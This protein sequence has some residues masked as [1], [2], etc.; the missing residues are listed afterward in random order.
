MELILEAAP[1][2]IVMANAGGT[3]LLVNAQTEK[4]FG[5]SR[6]ELIGKNVEMLIPES[7]RMHHAAAR[8]DYFRNP[9]ARAMGVGRDLYGLC[10]DGRE[11]PLEIG[12]NPVNTAKGVFVL[13]S[14]IDITERK[15]DEEALRHE[16][17]LLRTL[18][19]NLPDYIYVK[20]L[21]RR[22]VVANLAVAR[23]MGA[24]SPN[25]LLGKRD[26]DYYPETAS[27]EF[28]NDELGV[29]QAKP[30]INKSEPY[31]DKNGRRM[32]IL[33]SKLPL[34]DSTGRVVG[35]VGIGRDIT[36]LKHKEQALQDAM[37]EQEKLITKLQVALDHVKTLQGLLPI[38]A[39]CHK[40]RNADGKWERLESY[41]STRTEADFTHGFCPEC[42]EKHYGNYSASK[43]PKT[44]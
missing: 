16:R 7:V 1:N 37:V 12:L 17:N 30:L 6:A 38:C 25:A 26:E 29:F 10:K 33:T 34:H 41:I 36:E 2:A 40:I 11:I 15:R 13:A 9:A 31:T 8:G 24:E 27:K 21:E 43:S 23:L 22:F 28:C 20:D 5:Y 18:I 42:I 14:I 4:L 32:E 3:I 39:F 19:D 35:L 44:E